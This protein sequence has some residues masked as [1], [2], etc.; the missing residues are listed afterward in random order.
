M[1]V[2]KLYWA[3]SLALAGSLLVQ[4][5]ELTANEAAIPRSAGQGRVVTLSNLW[6]SQH[7]LPQVPLKIS[8]AHGPQLLLSDKPEYFYTGNGISLQELVQPGTVRL[9]IY[10]VPEPTNGLKV[11]SAVIENHGKKTLKFRFLRRAFPKPSRDYYLVGKTGLAQFYD[12]R[13]EKTFRHIPP[14]GR[15]VIDPDMDRTR[16][17]TGQL[18]HG[19]YEFEI[20]QPASVTVFERN[21]DE[22]SV[23]VIDRLPRLPRNL[24]G[25]EGSGA[26]RGIF[27][28]SD[29]DVTCEKGFVLDTARGPMQL[30]LADGKR[31]P[32]VR[33]RDDLELLD[34]VRDSGN[35]G[36][37]YHIKLK[38]SSSDRR[39]L[40]LLITKSEQGGQWCALQSGAVRVSC[41]EWPAGTVQIPTGRVAY[42]K[43]GEMVLIQ[44]FPP[45]H[46]GWTDTIDILYS[47]PGA[48]CIPTPMLLIPY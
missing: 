26:G 36:V 43:P 1:S 35:Y 44:K 31:D 9:Y 46:P 33:G 3:L 12:A 5:A 18:V 42:G 27:L 29:F 24:P 48:S 23:E 6:S 34:S 14:G 11:I 39:G 13:P 8:D 41:G 16:V 32:Y 15:M 45:A 38:H 7:D 30:V 20:N 19:F 47:P 10:H 40:A 22:S 28:S 4:A 2:R 37:L 21:P 25:H 17:T